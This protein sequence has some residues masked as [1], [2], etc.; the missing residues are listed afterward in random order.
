V[1]DTE[2]VTDWSYVLPG[3]EPAIRAEESGGNDVLG[4]NYYSPLVRQWDGHSAGSVSDGHGRS[5]H[6]PW[7][8]CEDVEFLPQPSPGTVMAWPWT[9]RR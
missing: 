3:D 7:I 6:S 9:R 5:D 4:V 1:T 2:A 8:G